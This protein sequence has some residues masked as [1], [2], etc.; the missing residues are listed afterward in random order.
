MGGGDGIGIC[1]RSIHSTEF[2]R[3]NWYF[4]GEFVVV[5]CLRSLVVRYRNANRN[6]LSVRWH[7]PVCIYFGIKP[8]I[9]INWVHI[10]RWIE[11]AQEKIIILIVSRYRLVEGGQEK[12]KKTFIAVS[13]SAAFPGHYIHDSEISVHA[14]CRNADARNL[15]NHSKCRNKFFFAFLQRNTELEVGVQETSSKL[16]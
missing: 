6:V 3:W 13:E 12:K 4:R 11:P 2:N 10:S 15:L 7:C 1:S 8:F 9:E 14:L 5:L 16:I